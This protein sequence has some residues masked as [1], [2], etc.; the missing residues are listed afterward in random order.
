MS[1]KATQLIGDLERNKNEKA[2][3]G[4]HYNDECMYDLKKKKSE[5]DKQVLAL[6]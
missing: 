3:Y 4:L 6:R 2:I 1:P 5:K